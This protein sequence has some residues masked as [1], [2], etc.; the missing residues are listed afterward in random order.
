MYKCK[1]SLLNKISLIIFH[2]SKALF[3]ASLLVVTKLC[4]IDKR[5]HNLL[6][7]KLI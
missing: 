1:N 5:V 6:T 3:L 2:R 7:I 4:N